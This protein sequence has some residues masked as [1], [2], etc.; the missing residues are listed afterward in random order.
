MKKQIKEK[1]KAH[2][3]VN[4]GIAKLESAITDMEGLIQGAGDVIDRQAVLD[5]L[6]AALTDLKG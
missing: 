2:K 3:P 4:E 1:P 5:K 6:K